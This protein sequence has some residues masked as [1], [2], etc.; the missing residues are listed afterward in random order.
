MRTFE[1]VEILSQERIHVAEEVKIGDSGRELAALLL[2][3]LKSCLRIA[4]GLS[5]AYDGVGFPVPL[6][7]EIHSDSISR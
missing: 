6:G 1:L 2:C 7:S 5:L 4:V 3:C